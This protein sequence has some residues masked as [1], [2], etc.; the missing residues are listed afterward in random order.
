M[1]DDISDLVT[2]N[3]LRET[4]ALDAIGD[5]A[6]P[7][8]QP[9]H[10]WRED[11]MPAVSDQLNEGA[12]LN[13][14]DV[15][16]TVDDGSKFYVGA[17]LECE[18][19]QMV[20]V[21]VATND[22]TVAARGHGDTAAAT[23]ADNTKVYIR[24]NAA[25]EGAD[26]PSSKH[27]D[28]A[29]KTN[30][31]QIFQPRAIEVSGTRLSSNVIGGA[32]RYESEKQKRLVQAMFDLQWAVFHGTKQTSNPAGTATVPRTMQGVKYW[33]QTNVS[34]LLGA[35][36]T[37]DKIEEILQAA[38]DNGARNLNLILC[39]SYNKRIFAQMMRPLKQMENADTT[40]MSIIDDVKTDFFTGQI[41]MVPGWPQAE[42]LVLSTENIS[43][44]PLKGR[45]F[46]H[47]E[48]AKTGDSKKGFVVGEY[49]NEVRHEETHIWIKGTAVSG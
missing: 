49:T 18:S 36:I 16:F 20:V 47:Q 5:S 22:V 19:E 42:I 24:G 8:T 27:S 48:L 31:T 1:Y 12:G 21:S 14:S 33:L 32:D 28:Y 26:P 2:I 37:P 35:K 4:P 11:S 40:M 10:Q 7:A 3:A 46:M 9:S 38:F 44:M 29:E 34:D 23:H 25:L 30:Y 13:N 43:V 45:S 41:M 6:Q 17:L 15:T 39:G